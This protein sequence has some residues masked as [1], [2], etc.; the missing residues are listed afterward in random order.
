M[1]EQHL[2]FEVLRR[3]QDGEDGE[4]DNENEPGGTE[5][6]TA[7][8]TPSPDDGNKNAARGFAYFMMAVVILFASCI[9]CLCIKSYRRRREQRLM[10]LRS[11][12]ADSVLGDMQMVPNED[13]DDENELI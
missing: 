12:Q 3:L 6:P 11:A 7:A 5:A 2:L 10:D 4:G 13:P 1:M 9:G 8:P